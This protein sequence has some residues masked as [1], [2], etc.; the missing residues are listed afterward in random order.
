MKTICQHVI[1]R[2]QRSTSARKPCIARAHAPIH[3][4]LVLL[5]SHQSLYC[6]DSIASLLPRYQVPA[7][8]VASQS[9]RLTTQFAY[10]VRIRRLLL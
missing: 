8:F 9:S 3:K 6:Q 7:V 1:L 2:N 4:L 10:S 5:I